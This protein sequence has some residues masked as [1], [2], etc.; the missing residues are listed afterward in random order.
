MVIGVFCIEVQALE[1]GDDSSQ[2]NFDKQIRPLFQKYCYQCHGPDKQKNGLRLDQKDAALKGGDLGQ[3]IV[4]GQSSKSPLYRYIAGLESEMVMP[5]KGPRLSKDEITLVQK[6]IDQGANW[7]ETSKNKPDEIWWSLK[8]LRPVMPP[9]PT[10]AGKKW[11]RTTIDNF[12]WDA[13]QKKGLIPGV[14]ADR[15]TLI[16]RLKY[17]LLGLPP[18]PEEVQAFVNDADPNAYEKLADQYLASPQYGE[19]WA[20]HWLDVVHYGETHG[21]DKD[22]PRPNAWPYRDYVIRAFNEDKPYHRFVEEQ[23]AGDVLYPGTRDGIEALGFIA[24]GPWDL[25][26]HAELP[27]TKIDGKIARH[28][29]RDDMVANTINTFQSLTIHCAQ[30]HNHKFDP[31]TSEDYYRLQ[32]VFSALDR[33]DK[34]FDIDPVVAAHRKKLETESRS[35]SEVVASLHEKRRSLTSPEL[36]QLNKDLEGIKRTQ[37]NTHPEFGYHS[38]LASKPDDIKWVQIDLGQVID[39]NRVEVIGCY[40]EFNKIGAGFGFPRKYRITASL[41]ED[42]KDEVVVADHSSPDNPGTL[43]QVFPTQVKARNVRFTAIELAPRQNDYMLALAEFRVFD[44]SGNNRALKAK[45]TALDSIEAPARWSKA[46]LVDGF[47][48]EPIDLQRQ[49]MLEQKQKQLQASLIPATLRSEIETA[50]KKLKSVQKEIRTLPAPLIVYAGTVHYGSGN[51]IGTGKNGGRPRPI[52]LLQ[53]GN[54]QKPQKEVEPGTLSLLKELPGRLELSA[55]ANEG[56]RRAALAKWITHHDNPLTWRSIVN[57]V[58]LYHFGQGLVETPNDFGKMGQ[59]PSHP[60]LLDWLANDF[61]QHGSF[62]KLHKM[63]VMSSGYR[64]ASQPGGDTTRAQNIDGANRL[65]WKMNRRRLEAEAI[66]DS[67]LFTAGKLDLTMGGPSYQDYVVEKPEHSPHYRYELK[68]PTDPKLYRRSIYRSIVRSQQNPWMAT[69]DCADP[70]ILVDK[71]N[72][73]TSPLQ[74]LALLNDPLLVLM[75]KHFSDRLKPLSGTAE[76]VKAAMRWTLQREPSPDE[77]R[78]LSAYVDKQGLEQLGRLLWNLNEFN[79]VD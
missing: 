57:R 56:Q 61:R 26:G 66:R 34:Q 9:V 14:E 68:D 1:P 19:R 33:A 29:D 25:I 62:K 20:R 72:Q 15:R 53:R 42:M 2:I 41:N 63:I 18:T 28:L 32:A 5:P 74:A 47:V 55:D 50:E 12:L 52:H 31:I 44:P 30:C 24:S 67:I 78:A 37:G 39:I 46:N 36:L 70:S 38:Q 35:A 77:L 43:P 73:T 16:R 49:R 17:D 65:L 71:R 45:V 27:E 48:P 13:L 58:W 6:W 22:Q 69:M 75:S 79:F 21:Y 40:D 4:P 60:E 54:V 8:P 10:E 64:Q 51:F 3:A 11:A 59:L 76:R 7:Q 23:L